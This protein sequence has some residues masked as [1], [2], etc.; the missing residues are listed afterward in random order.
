MHVISAF[1]VMSGHQFVR[2]KINIVILTSIQ[3]K[4]EVEAEK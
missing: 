4:K 2:N 3:M 1:Q